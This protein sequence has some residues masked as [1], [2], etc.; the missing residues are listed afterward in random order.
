M[1]ADRFKARPS[2]AQCALHQWTH[3]AS[4]HACCHPGEAESPSACPSR[5]PVQRYSIAIA[6]AP[7]P[8]KGSGEPVICVNCP[9]LSTL[10]I[11][12]VSV[13][14]LPT[15]RKCPD[16]SIVTGAGAAPEASWTGEP[17]VNG[18]N[19]PLTAPIV[20]PTT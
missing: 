2:I 18:V 6:L 12:I 19:A 16:G 4:G 7:E 3:G 8:E 20:K 17:V 10:N 9:E 5:A 14:V 1:P 11:E 13:N 15:Y